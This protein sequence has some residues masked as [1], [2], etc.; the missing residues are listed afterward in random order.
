MYCFS[1]L[2][3]LRALLLQWQRLPGTYRDTVDARTCWRQSGKPFYITVISTS[4]RFVVFWSK[5]TT[6]RF[7]LYSEILNQLG[8]LCLYYCIDVINRLMHVDVLTNIKK[9]QCI[10][11]IW[12]RNT[13]LKQRICRVLI[14]R[15]P[16]SL[17]TTQLP[18][19][20]LF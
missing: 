9:E 10:M 3:T 2:W 16:F 18:V 1:A 8:L 13:D 11:K 14:Q 12:P 20:N 19:I 17:L 5:L 4:N 6:K 7:T 15:Q